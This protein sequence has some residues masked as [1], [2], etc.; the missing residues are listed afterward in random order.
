MGLI[1][2]VTLTGL[3]F[4]CSIE[5]HKQVGRPASPVRFLSVFAGTFTPMKTEVVLCYLISHAPR[6]G[7]PCS[8]SLMYFEALPLEHISSTNFSQSYKAASPDSVGTLIHLT[9]S[10]STGAYVVYSVCHC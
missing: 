4:H 7:R 3:H 8:L 6:G 2:V 10:L 5:P 1:C 9:K